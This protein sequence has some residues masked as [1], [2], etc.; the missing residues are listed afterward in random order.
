M[1]KFEVVGLMSGTS[2]D[3]LDVANCTFMWDGKNQW[4]YQISDALTIPFPKDLEK[5]LRNAMQLNGYD[6]YACHVKY[7]QW[8]GHSLKNE[9]KN[10]GWQPCLVASHGQ[11]V[12]HQPNKSLS[13]QIGDGMAMHAILKLPVINNFR[14]LDVHLGGQGAPLVPIGDK[15]LFSDYDICLNLGGFS[16]ISF[17]NAS[18]IRMAYDVCPVNTVLNHLAG[19]S[20]LPYDA[21]GKLAR[22]GQV[23]PSLFDDLEA[24]PYYKEKA[25]KSLGFEWVNQ[26]VMPLIEAC[27]HAPNEDL[28][29]TCTRH[30]AMQ[31]AREIKIQAT[32]KS[33][34]SVLTTGGGAYNDFLIDSVKNLAGENFQIIIPESRLIDYKE[35]L[36]FGFLGLLRALGK[37]NTLKEVTGAVED[38]CGG[39]IYDGLCPL[40]L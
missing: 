27:S 39:V 32:G 40:N 34:F 15:I 24:L 20:G 7:G 35:A 10:R 23:I 33:A 3:G 16:N 17:D 9:I 22:A 1:K 13:L 26:F 5:D 28:L 25:P 21:G 18:G 11:T 12:F 30:F 38:S 36:I 8:M 29:A 14:I 4:A 19:F 31:I 2:L 6:L 37:T